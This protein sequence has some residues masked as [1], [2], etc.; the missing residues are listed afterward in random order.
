MTPEQSLKLKPGDRV[1]FNGYESDQGTVKATN[2]KYVSIKWDDGHV[3][4]TGH[5]DMAR[6][7]VAELETA[8]RR[9]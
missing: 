5:R 6:V 9:K 7:D 4:Y 1:Y 3:S 8:K 2:G